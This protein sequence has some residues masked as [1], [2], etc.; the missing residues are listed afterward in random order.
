MPDAPEPQHRAR[1]RA[2]S[3]QAIGGLGRCSKNRL[4]P[5]VLIKQIKV[6]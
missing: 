2:P 3:P 4:P 5:L 1:G 6:A